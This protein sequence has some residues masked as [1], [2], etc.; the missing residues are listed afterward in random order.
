[1]HLLNL[2]NKN[3]TG[4]INRILIGLVTCI[5][6][7]STAAQSQHII[8]KV[9]QGPPNLPQH[10]LPAPEPAGKFLEPGLFAHTKP[11]FETYSAT[12]N[13]F[14]G[15]Q[16]GNLYIRQTDADHVQIITKPEAGWHW[17]MEGARLSPD[18]KQIAIKQIDDRAVPTIPLT[19]TATGE[20][21]FKAYSRA[22]QPIPKNQFY[23]V[24][25]PSGKSIK[26]NHDT[27]LPYIHVIGWSTDGKTVRLLQANRLLKKL[28]L[29]TAAANTGSCTTLLTEWSDTYLVGLNLLQGYSDKL[30]AMN[31]AWFLEN[32]NQFIWTSE[33]SGFNQLYIYNYKGA[34]I[35]PISTKN[36]NGIVSKLVHV[37]EKNDWAYFYALGDETQPYDIQLFRTSLTTDKI[38]KISEGPVIMETLFSTSNDSIW[39]WR[40]RLPDMMQ[41]DLLHANGQLI[42][43]TWKADLNPLK[44]TGLQPEYTRVL[45]ADNKTML[46]AMLLKPADFNLALQYPVVEYIYGGPNTAIIPRTIFDRTM[47][48]M[49]NLANQGFIVVFI[50][51]RGTPERG[52]AFSNYSYGKLGQVEIIDH[53]A[54]IKKLGAK[55]PYMNLA[56]VGITGHSWGGYFALQAM[57]EEPDFYKAGHLSAGAVD[58]ENFRIAVE[59]FM[60]CLP[61]DCTERYKLAAVTNKLNRLKGALS[62]NHGTAD[63]DVPIEEAYKLIDA[64]KKAGFT[65]YVFKAYPGMDHIIMRNKEW[66]PEMIDFFI[67]QLK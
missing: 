50:D 39:V 8:D 67:Q 27:A 47:W 1:M 55:R 16:N 64:L 21:S 49:Q 14:I 32:K 42:N 53:I 38:E 35:K 54:V 48:N 25:I 2:P 28:E 6:F 46:E 51:G 17:N 63:D 45:A 13:A 52:K 24:D 29:S 66:E 23:I 4:H 11:L 33:Q 41:I 19:H 44:E 36:K 3:A 5:L 18:G 40:T 60:G 10:L 20:T 7:F 65:N 62:I 30:T 34:L 9:M 57:I 58:P 26:I 15:T 56:K 37:D 12:N 31:L 61:A 43:T 59:P 22:G